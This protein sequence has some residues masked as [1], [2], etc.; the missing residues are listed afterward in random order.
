MKNVLI[1]SSIALL[2]SACKLQSHSVDN[3]SK[4]KT[5]HLHLNPKPGSSYHYDIE[6]NSEIKISLDN[7]EVDNINKSKVGIDYSID[8]DS[9]GNF[10]LSIAY[11]K[12]HVYSRNGDKENDA[13][14]DNARL[15]L[16]PTERML[17]ILKNASLTAVV[18]PTGDVKDIRGYKEL[19][20]RL[21][22][23]L[24]TSD[25][26]VKQVAQAQLDKIIG[27]QMVQKNLDQLFKIF[28]DSAIH[29]GDKWKIN[30]VQNGD[31]KL[32]VK[33]TF[34]LDDINSEIAFVKSE[35]EIEGDRMPLAM[36][37]YSVIP[38]LKGTQIASYEIEAKT[39]MLL[40]S[41][42]ESEVKGNLQL[43]GREIPINIKVEVTIKGE[44]QR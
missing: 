26:H 6:N 32:N 4:D 37:G 9:S 25:A 5:F 44:K 36:M 11:D 21:M 19:S 38:D 39:G 15:S 24:D 29:I 17:G 18:T 13:D 34:H 3:F 40:N 23:G 2:I 1:I 10:L 20:S 22:A 7:N 30:A 31:F 43:Q 8:K 41:S 28:P 16:N 27:S 14:A 35:S 42:I 12:I 33:S